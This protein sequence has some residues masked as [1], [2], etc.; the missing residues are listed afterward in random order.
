MDGLKKKRRKLAVAQIWSF[1]A[2]QIL[3]D[4]A[5][6]FYEVNEVVMKT[7]FVIFFISSI[8]PLCLGVVN[9]VMAARTAYT[10]E[11]SLIPI[12]TKE[13]LA[14]IP[15]F[16]INFFLWFFLAGLCFNP[17]LM[18]LAPGF[19]IVGITVSYLYFIAANLPMFVYVIARLIKHR[20]KPTKGIVW[21]L[22]FQA[23]Y[24]LDFIGNFIFKRADK[25]DCI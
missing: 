9:S 20:R 19:M 16:I 25:K 14:L 11:E 12:M 15:W 10:V 23:I 18:V 4:I 3:P 2:L 13:K 21:A 6:K 24:F 1:Y 17:F 22:I 7:I 5:F 8:F